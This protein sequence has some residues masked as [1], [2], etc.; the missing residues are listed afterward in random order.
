MKQLVH[1]WAWA[2]VC[3]LLVVSA[4]CGGGQSG[5]GDGMTEPV[6]E[7]SESRARSPEAAA[8]ESPTEAAASEPDASDPQA[9]EATN[10]TDAPSKGAAADA[11]TDGP[12]AAPAN[13]GPPPEPGTVR[14]AVIFLDEA[15]GSETRA[16][17]KLGKLLRKIKYKRKRIKVD[18]GTASDEETQAARALM[19]PTVTDATIPIPAIWLKSETVVV[20]R[21]LPP[22]VRKRKRKKRR[23]SQGVGDIVVLR[24]PSGA[25]VYSE[26]M[27]GP[28]GPALDSQV[29]ATWIG[30]LVRASWQSQ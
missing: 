25:P 9:T 3:A 7:T 10:G 14:V 13:A 11:R 5:G 24:P 23:I 18:I 2:C 20:L 21:V 15:L 6:D 26:A 30:E 4:G 17:T 28:E 19:D 22:R 8:A 12:A 1:A 27:T 16:V 29:L